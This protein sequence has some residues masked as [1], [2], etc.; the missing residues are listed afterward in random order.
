MN[1]KPRTREEKIGIGVLLV[2]FC[3]GMFVGA[4]LMAVG[5]G[6][7]EDGSENVGSEQTGSA[8]PGPPQSPRTSTPAPTERNGGGAT[9]Q[10]PEKIRLPSL[11][12]ETYPDALDQVDEI[13]FYNV[14]PNDLLKE[15]E[16]RPG[17]TGNQWSVCSQNPDPGLYEPSRE[18]VL[19]VVNKGLG[20]SCPEA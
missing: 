5:E 20:E 9:T 12:G 4:T 17:L 11:V 8:W 15:R 10:K 13:G 19:D 18:I 7:A 1:L 2:V 16:N 14:I 3:G 6:P